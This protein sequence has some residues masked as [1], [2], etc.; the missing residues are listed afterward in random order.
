[1]EHRINSIDELHAEAKKLNSDNVQND[2][3]NKIKTLQDTITLLSTV[4]G[5]DDAEVNINNLRYVCN[6]L[7]D[8]RTS[9]CELAT[10]SA[11]VAVKYRA[12]Q[13]S[14]GAS[15]SQLERLVTTEAASKYPGEYQDTIGDGV[16]MSKDEAK[17]CRDKVA[18]VS[19]ELENSK[20][21]IKNRMDNIENNW[22]AGPK[23]DC[24]DSAYQTFNTN[25]RNYIDRLNEVDKALEHAVSNYE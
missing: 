24:A 6:G 7:I 3:D 22:T 12:I 19:S 11:D 18:R 13:I 23:R 5:G 25:I 2:L 10:A 4:W 14:G 17:S 21:N 9:L 1:M 8:L 20:T 15:T 16:N